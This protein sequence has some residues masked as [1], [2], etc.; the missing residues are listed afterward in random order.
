MFTQAKS[1][2]SLV[3]SSAFATALN[4][5]ENVI[6]DSENWVKNLS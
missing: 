6:E 2:Q 1:T 3:Q 4:D 5:G